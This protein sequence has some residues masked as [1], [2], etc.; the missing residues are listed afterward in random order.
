MSL[1]IEGEQCAFCHA[2]LFEDDDIV[3]CPECGAPHHR[4]CYQKKG[5]CGM[6]EFHGT[7][8]Q[9]DVLK[10]KQKNEQTETVKEEK[11]PIGSKIT[12]KCHMCGEEYDPSCKVCP[13]CSAPNVASM[14]G[15][16]HF[17]F[18]GGVPADFDIGEGVTA[19]EAKRFVA[20]NTTRYI[21]KFAAI[22][23]GKK[24]S[25]NWLA[26]LF[27]AG[28]FLSRKM[29]IS[30]IFVGI[31]TVAI[32]LLQFPF[33]LAVNNLGL[34]ENA[35][36]MQISQAVTENINTIGMP[37]VVLAFISIVLNLLL[38]IFS[39]VLGDMLYRKHVISKIKQMRAESEDMD[40]D[41]RKYGGVSLFGMILGLLAVQYLPTI[42]F[43][44]LR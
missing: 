20:S 2:Y 24:S 38:R 29:N 32:T 16:F 40:A 8:M 28:W 31:L 43:T 6:A 11:T 7:D 37:I 15:I 25:W 4:E 41:Y 21:P 39:A 12:T 5:V 27:P 23:E 14:G 26:F 22:K 30:G 36:Y 34:A 17:D 13:R 9:Y 44:F 33:V 35:N 3:Y 18:L 1:S 19:D 42:I 10:N